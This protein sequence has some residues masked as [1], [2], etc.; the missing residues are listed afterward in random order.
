MALAATFAGNVS[1]PSRVQMRKEYLDR[2]RRKGSGRPFHSLREPGAEIAYV[3]NLVETINSGKEEGTE[4][5][6]GHSPLWLGAYA[7]RRKR[8]E[9]LFGQSRDPLVDEGVLASM[10]GC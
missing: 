6:T 2:L 5:V 1:L 10:V 4:L 3:S 8:L 7:R 9:A